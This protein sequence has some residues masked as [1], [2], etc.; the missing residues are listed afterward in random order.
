MFPF[1]R[2]VPFLCRCFFLFCGRKGVKEN[3]VFLPIC[4]RFSHASFIERNGINGLRLGV[5]AFAE[6]GYEAQLLFAGNA[7]KVSKGKKA[8]LDFRSE[9]AGLSAVETGAHP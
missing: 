4:F 8:L 3:L 7:G 6:R 1:L 2:V 5:S 9:A